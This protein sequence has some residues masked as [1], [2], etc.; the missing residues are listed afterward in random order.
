MHVAAH[1][2]RWI[3]GSSS[4]IWTMAVRS[5]FPPL[6]RPSVALAR[7]WRRLAQRPCNWFIFE[8]AHIFLTRLHLSAAQSLG[9]LWNLLLL[10]FASSTFRRYFPFIASHDPSIGFR[11]PNESSYFLDTTSTPRGSNYSPNRGRGSINGRPGEL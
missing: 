1:P 5:A 4:L 9:W 8:A 7:K 3:G 11:S 10:G 6:G 2:P